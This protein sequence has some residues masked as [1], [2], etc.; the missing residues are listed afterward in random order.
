MVRGAINHP[1]V[2]S[3]QIITCDVHGVIMLL[4]RIHMLNR[5]KKCHTPS[6]FSQI[7]NDDCSSSKIEGVPQ[8]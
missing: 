3:P 5:N 1:C 8:K 2:P 6:Y 7:W 4:W